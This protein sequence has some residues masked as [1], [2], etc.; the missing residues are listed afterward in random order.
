MKKLVGAAKIGCLFLCCAF[1][2]FE[3]YILAQSNLLTASFEKGPEEIVLVEIETQKVPLENLLIDDPEPEPMAEPEPE[4]E[5]QFEPEP[6]ETEPPKPTETTEPPEEVETTAQVPEE[7][8]APTEPEEPEP[9]AAPEE[10]AAKNV[11][12]FMYHT[13]SESYPGGLADLYVKPSEFEKQIQYLSENGY[14]FCTFDDYNNLNNIEK[15]VFLTFDDGYHENYTEIFPILQKYNAKITIFLIINNIKA[16]NF[17]V[18]MIREMNDSGLVKFEAHTLNHYDLVAISANDSKLDSELLGCKEQIEE[19]TG[20]P[21]LALAYP[22]GKFNE[23]VK[24]KTRQY[25][26]F[27]L[28]ADLGMH[29]T[30]NDPYEISRIR[31]NRSTSIVG[32]VNALG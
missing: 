13:S 12:I 2:V 7:T 9:T 16:E 28:R 31:V 19:I 32:F 29:N 18:E 17:T 1:I 10:L 11:P 21:V 5:T 30:K 6:E 3:I 24:N 8:E 15:P 14:T 22:A 20:K 23:A 25:F 27:G 4:P 26:A